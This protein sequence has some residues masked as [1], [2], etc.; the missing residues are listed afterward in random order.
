MQPSQLVVTTAWQNTKRKKPP[1][2]GCVVLD[3]RNAIQ[4]DTNRSE[5]LTRAYVLLSLL[6]GHTVLQ[7]TRSFRWR[8]HILGCVLG[9]KCQNYDAIMRG[10][11][12]GRPNAFGPLMLTV[13]WKS[14]IL[15]HAT[16]LYVGIFDWFHWIYVRSLRLNEITISCSPYGHRMGTSVSQATVSDT[17]VRNYK[18]FA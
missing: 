4:N 8:T 17:L 3:R 11:K 18:W 16:R 2:K 5:L 15:L 13:Q 12:C 14:I 7:L 1:T 6:Q 10:W 9:T